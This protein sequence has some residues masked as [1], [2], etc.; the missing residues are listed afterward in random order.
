VEEAKSIGAHAYVAKSKAGEA[1]VK[2]VETAVI[3][4]DFVLVD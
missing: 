1:L 4:G 3:G 2:A